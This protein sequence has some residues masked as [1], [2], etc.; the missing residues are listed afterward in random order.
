MFVCDL[1]DLMTTK[2]ENYETEK[3]TSGWL[4]DN[5]G[6]KAEWKVMSGRKAIL[7]TFKLQ[8]KIASCQLCCHT[9]DDMLFF[10][11]TAFKKE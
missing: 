3:T 9:I 5:E 4:N 1:H 10:I 2:G 8:R 7:K 11:P 6:Q